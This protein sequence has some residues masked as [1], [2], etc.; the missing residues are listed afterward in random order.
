VDIFQQ[1]TN[2]V[3]GREWFLTAVTNIDF[4]SFFIAPD[5]HCTNWKK[6][7]TEL[8]KARAYC[9]RKLLF[10]APSGCDNKQ[11]HFSRKENERNQK[12]LVDLLS[13]KV[14]EVITLHPTSRYN[15]CCKAG[16]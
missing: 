15:N 8:T 7:R 2:V 4:K 16:S 14:K 1:Q 12:G 11:K 6:E 5:M 13:Q 10:A 9:T 3:N